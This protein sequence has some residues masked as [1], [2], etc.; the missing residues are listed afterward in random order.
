MAK[1]EP[2]LI[3]LFRR[4]NLDGPNGCWEWTG[5]RDDSG[6]GVINEDG[7]PVAV[8]RVSYETFVGPIPPGL[9]ACHTCDNPPCFRPDHL[10]AGT[11]AENM[12]DMASKGRGRHVTNSHLT[13]EQARAIIADARSDREIGE[14]Y[15]V[16]PS[17][18]WYIKSGRSWKHL[19]GLP[20]ARRA[21]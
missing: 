21:A 6:Y 11:H 2:I 12:R 5:R 3:R 13:E 10:F 16:H 14:T 18:V 17:T 8:H 7:K 9:L 4:A 1:P 15:G 20:R 19:A